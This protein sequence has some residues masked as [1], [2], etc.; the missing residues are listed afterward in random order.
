VDKRIYQE[1]ECALVTIRNV[2]FAFAQEQLKRKLFKDSALLSDNTEHQVSVL[3]RIQKES[4]SGIV[5]GLCESLK[6]ASYSKLA[7]LKLD[8]GVP[9][10]PSAAPE[11]L[12]EVVS[13]VKLA[14]EE[15]TSAKEVDFEIL[16]R[17]EC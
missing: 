5:Q 3:E 12:E 15:L 9:F 14:L 1:Q 16:T 17:D 11:S 13:E 4:S 6:L 7:L 10:K 2:S 8:Q